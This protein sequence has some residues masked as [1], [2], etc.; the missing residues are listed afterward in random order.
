VQAGSD[1]DGSSADRP[2]GSTAALEAASGAGDLIVLLASDAVFDGGLALKSGQTLIGRSAG[3]RLPVI[4]NR[5]TDRNRGNGIVLADSVRIWNLRVQD[6]YASGIFGIDVSGVSISNVEVVSANR[7]IDP[8]VTRAMNETT[9]LLAAGNVEEAQ[10]RIPADLDALVAAQTGIR[11]RVL[12]MPVTHGG[13]V[14]LSSRPTVSSTTLIAQSAIVDATGVGIAVIARAGARHRLLATD[15]R[16]EGG[17]AL[18][19]ID[20]GVAGLAEGTSSEVQLELSHVRVLGRMSMGGRNVAVI[21]SEDATAAVRIDGSYIG[22]SGQD[23]VAAA[24]AHLPA[25]AEI[26]VLNSTIENAAQT[27]VEGTMFALPP[28]DPARVAESRVSV[29][30]SGSTIR[31]AGAVAGFEKMAPSNILI[32]GSKMTPEPQPFP[33]GRYALTVRNS[34]I[35]GATRFGIRIG[36]SGFT[37]EAPDESEFAVLIRDTTIA[38]NGTAEIAIDEPKV[39]IDARHNCWGDPAG[40]RESHIVRRGAADARLDVSEPTACGPKK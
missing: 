37:G 36:V 10:K 32:L 11:L 38:G 24:A 19:P 35:E 40:L 30:I 34:T 39:N 6:T 17:A 3:G 7:G 13:I 20:T 5:N 27:N 1:G 33:R 26:E 12:G 15:T 14:L 22:Q 2:L 25:V 4:T 29:T 9:R 31:N 21:A 23:G 18:G 28:S 16:V 8:A